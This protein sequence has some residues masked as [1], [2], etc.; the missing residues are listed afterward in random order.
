[1][2]MTYALVDATNQVVNVILVPIDAMLD[3]DGNIDETVGA[4]YCQQFHNG[5]WI[6]TCLN[7]SVRKNY[8]VSGSTYDPELDAFILPKPVERAVFDR[9]SCQWTIDGFF[10]PYSELRQ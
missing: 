4:E 5:T 9:E 3:E 2:T 1:M 6:R 8:A 7:G 10:P